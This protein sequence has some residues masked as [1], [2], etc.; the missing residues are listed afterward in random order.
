MAITT[1][2]GQTLEV[3]TKIYYTGDMANMDG[4]GEITNE[5]SDRWGL[6]YE[7]A[8]ND[9]REMCITPASFQPSAGRRFVTKEH[10]TKERQEKI[11]LMQAELTRIANLKK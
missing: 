3:G 4:F 6:R 5:I 11:A 2:D 1:Q 10:Y 8:M 9:G 7:I